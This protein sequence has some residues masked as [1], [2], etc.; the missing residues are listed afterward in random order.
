MFDRIIEYEVRYG[1]DWHVSIARRDHIQVFKD[2]YLLQFSSPSDLKEIDYLIFQPIHTRGQV[3][4]IS[5][6]HENAVPNL[7]L[8]RPRS[9]IHLQ[10]PCVSN[11]LTTGSHEHDTYRDHWSI[12]A[13]PILLPEPTLL[14]MESHQQLQYFPLLFLPNPSPMPA[15]LSPS[16][17]QLSP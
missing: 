9:S 17:H 7:N 12:C 15:S 16:T 4:Y 8:R 14:R 2:I 13:S 10:D 6:Y 3:F 1:L 5:N 11:S